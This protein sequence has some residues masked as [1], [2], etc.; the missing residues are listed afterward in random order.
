IPQISTDEA[1]V[2]IRWENISVPFKVGTNTTQRVLADARAAVAAA[3]PDDWRTPRQAAGFAND[4]GLTKEASEWIEQS[5][6]ANANMSN[7][8]LKAQI[9]AKAGDKAGAIKTAEMA[10]SK[11]TDKDKEVADEIRKSIASW[12]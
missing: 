12:R 2:V 6:K 10:L 9:Q 3:K 11:A 8:Y 7:L 4:A 5:V 1:T